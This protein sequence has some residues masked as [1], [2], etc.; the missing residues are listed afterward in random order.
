MTGF[1]GFIAE[2]LLIRLAQKDVQFY[3]LV[4][5]EFVEKAMQEVERIALESTAPLENFTIVKG[6][7][8]QGNLGIDNE[9][10][11]LLRDEVT[12][13]FHL[14]AIYDLEVSRD[15]A[16][17]VN[18]EGTKNVNEFV[19]SIASLHRYNYI[20]TCYVAGARKGRIFETELDHNK[21]FLNFYEEAK[22][23][24]EQ[25][26]EKLKEEINVTVYRPSVVVGD[27]K[28]GET[29]KYDGIYYLIK[30]MMRNPNILRMVNVGNKDVRLNLVPVDFVADAIAELSGDDKAIGKT[31]A[32]ADPDPLTTKD[33]FDLIAE[34]LSG[35]RSVWNPPANL[36]RTFLSSSIS[37]AITGLPLSAV[38]YFYTPKT[39]DTSIA[40]EL[41]TQHGV[42]CPGFAVYISNLLDFVK[43]NPDL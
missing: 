10:L 2:R 31:V 40:D 1:P 24:A 23:L 4:Q 41:L 15:A 20:S 28:T 13:V 42:R 25:E 6:D 17:S 11:K 39:Y 36:V 33:L 32:L 16:M 37:P 38:P 22:Y 8:T 7:I 29:S 26:V 43:K 35:K 18:V 34:N 27:S 9:D 30:Y 21:G 19:R 14:A 12:D 3:L 5:Q